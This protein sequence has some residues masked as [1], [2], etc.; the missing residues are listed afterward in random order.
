MGSF[1]SPAGRSGRDA[2]KWG[3]GTGGPKIEVKK[4]LL[5]NK[6]R[7]YSRGVR[8]APISGMQSRRRRASQEGGGLTRWW[9][10][11]QVGAEEWRRGSHMGCRLGERLSQCN[12]TRGI[13]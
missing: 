1:L 6:G 9:N 11:D 13:W 8:Q 7:G 2:P 12:Q 3:R 5:K 10:G 4:N